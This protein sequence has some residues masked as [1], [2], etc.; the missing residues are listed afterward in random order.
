MAKKAILQQYKG[1][2]VNNLHA[3]PLHS[4]CTL[5][6][7]PAEEDYNALVESMKSRGYFDDQP[8][9]LYADK[10]SESSDEESIFVLDGRNRLLAAMDSGA[11]PKFLEYV[12]DDPLGF[13][14]SR[15]LSR[16]HM[17]SG[18]KAALAA[19][20]ADLGVGDN[21]HA[22]GTSQAEAASMVKAS[23]TGIKKFNKVKELDPELAKKVEMGEVALDAAYNK[24]R[25]P[26]EPGGGKGQRPE[27]AT[28]P[29]AKD[30]PLPESL[31]PD[32]AEPK[33][34]MNMEF[35]GKSTHPDRKFKVTLNRGPFSNDPAGQLDKAR[36]ITITGLGDAMYRLS[37]KEARQLAVALGNAVDKI[38]DE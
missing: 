37:E 29:P 14:L 28:P 4:M 19:K 33:G 38:S 13:V 35:D 23:K 16:R 22:E 18:Q 36:P 21:Q 7:E 25:E 27:E 31:T 30:K 32:P 10:A 12:G 24:V 5:F 17:T 26:A 6:P 20:I 3:L 8:I 1:D 15:N 9:I 11:V 2:E 34:S